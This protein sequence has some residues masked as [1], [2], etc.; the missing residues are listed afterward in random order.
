MNHS[1]F[2]LFMTC[3]LIGM[4]LTGCATEL[5]PKTVIIPE[6]EP[7]SE[8]INKEFAVNK[9]YK[10]STT[11]NGPEEYRGDNYFLGWN[12]NNQLVETIR[13]RSVRSIARVDFQSGAAQEI[14]KLP[15]TAQCISLSPDG[16]QLAYFADEGLHKLMLVNLLDQTET[17]LWDKKDS[18]NKDCTL[19]WSANSQ[20]L[21]FVALDK[22]ELDPRIHRYDVK[23]KGLR[24]FSIPG[25][26]V[27]TITLGDISDEG[28]RIL[29]TKHVKNGTSLVSGRIT[30]NGFTQEFE[31]PIG[32]GQAFEYLN[33]NQILFASAEGSLILY[34]L[35][36]ST[37]ITLMEHVGTFQ[38]SKDHKYIVYAKEQGDIYA[39]KFQ[40][41]SLVNEKLLYKGWTPTHMQWSPDNKKIIFMNSRYPE[42]SSK[43]LSAPAPVPDRDYDALLIA[44][45]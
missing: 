24:V 38:L 19:H 44:L 14:T 27:S 12:D 5:E 28:E 31:H 35:R 26:T 37:S 16:V 21:S 34:D 36:N 18:G 1:M 20:Y 4:I 33:S 10:L 29:I 41:N 3:L 39:A 30:D 11:R 25:W 45:Q 13:N 43:P 2:R 15:E 22:G 7:S 23:Q 32:G 42:V 40:G 17:S 6:A 8:P 9:I